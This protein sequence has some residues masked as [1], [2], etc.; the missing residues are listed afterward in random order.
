MPT[1]RSALTSL[2]TFRVTQ[3]LPPRAP[4]ASPRSRG[5]RTASESDGP[6]PSRLLGQG[7]GGSGERGDGPTY[8]P[9]E[10]LPDASNNSANP[11]FEFLGDDGRSYS[12]KTANEDLGAFLKLDDSVYSM[13]RCM[14]PSHPDFIKAQKIFDDLE[15]RRIPPLIMEI[16]GLSNQ[17]A[18]EFKAFLREAIARK[19]DPNESDE[20]FVFERFNRNGNS[21]NVRNS[22]YKVDLGENRLPVDLKLGRFLI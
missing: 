22:S 4:S 6:Q 19:V 1:T 9:Q 17:N 13:I 18:E 5:S 12:L 16:D 10:P 3:R 7:E 14:K 11:F 2:T 21:Q 8:A 15:S 20:F